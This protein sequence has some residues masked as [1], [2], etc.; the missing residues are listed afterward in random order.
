MIYTKGGRITNQSVNTPHRVL[1]SD[2]YFY[3][4]SLD[5]NEPLN[6]DNKGDTFQRNDFRFSLEIIPSFLMLFDCYM[7]ITFCCKM[8]FLVY[9]LFFWMYMKCKSFSDVRYWDFCFG[10]GHN[11]QF[12]LPLT[13]GLQFLFQFLLT[14]L[15]PSVAPWGNLNACY[16]LQ[17]RGDTT[18]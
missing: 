15:G 6:L 4:M 14:H 7:R 1:M 13:E 17:S 16:R 8:T 5:N 18:V 12:I 3:K 11:K 9:F 2:N 10:F